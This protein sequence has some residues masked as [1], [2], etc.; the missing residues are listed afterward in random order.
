VRTMPHCVAPRQHCSNQE[1]LM[2]ALMST[3]EYFI[4]IEIVHA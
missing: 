1:N 3:V 2:Y 4:S